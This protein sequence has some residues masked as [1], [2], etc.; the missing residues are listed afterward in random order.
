VVE[1]GRDQGVPTLVIT[2]DPR[3]PLA[4]ASEHVFELEAGPELAVAATKTYT[5][6]LIALAMLSAS[7]ADDEARWTSLAGVPEQMEA[8]LGSEKTL[9][10]AAERLQDMEHC[11]VIG[12][13]FNLATAFEWSLK[14]KELAYV[15]AAPYSSADF[16]HGPIA[17]VDRDFPVL[18]MIPRGAVRDDLV[19]LLERL[20]GQHHAQ[21]L[22]LSDDETAL[23]FAQI[24]VALPPGLE[25]WLSPIVGIVAAQLFTYH[26]TSLKGLDTE[27]PRGLRKITRSD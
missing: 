20:V 1:G 22:V 13:G 14:L 16:R 17:V 2:N 3:S 27:Q 10:S 7:L 8:V 6:Q 11:V 4:A 18:A 23:S 9:E 12:R 19:D 15:V 21:T 5:S 25:E 24:P 26:L